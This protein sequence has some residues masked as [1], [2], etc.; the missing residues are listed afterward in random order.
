MMKPYVVESIENNGK[1]KKQFKPV[2]LNG[3][4]CSKATADTLTR[5]L[6]MVTLEGTASRLKN[7]RCTVAGKTG[8]SRMFLQTEERR[9]SRD[10][11]SDIDGRKKHQATFVG[12]FP[13][14]K[15]KYT[16]I[17]VVYTDF[18]SH[19]VYG[20]KIPALTFKEIVD[21]IWA[22]DSSWG[23]EY[24]AKGRMPE[25][26]AP[27]ISTAKGTDSPV[28][29]LLGLGLKDALYAIENNG[30]RCSYTGT[31]HVVKQTPSAGAACRKGETIKIELR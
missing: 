9:G 14:E 20:G 8:T 4:I 10:P 27:H 23:S 21:G 22:M 17:V 7:A 11:Y 15:P 31:G 30:Y 25:M 28:P 2:I 13:A 5:A 3:S 12:F 1:V 16:A 29:D 24:K 26:R 19:N 6:T 18:I